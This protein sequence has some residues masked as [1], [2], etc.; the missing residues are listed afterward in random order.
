MANN[1]LDFMKDILASPLGELI[2]SVGQGVADAQAALDAGSLSKLLELYSNED[3]ELLKLMRAVGYQP[4]F[5]VI[6]ETEVEA[7]ISLA[8]SGNEISSAVMGENGVTKQVVSQK[9]IYAAPLNA[10][11][12]NKFNVQAT[13]ATKIKFKIIPVPPTNA[14]A[15]LRVAPNLIGL[16]ETQIEALLV[17]F[18][19]SYSVGDDSGSGAV[20]TQTPEAGSIVKEGDVIVV[21]L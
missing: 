4:T 6:P 20:I 16:T 11:T 10:S 19:L 13:A 14:A 21:D 7:S 5:Y 9:Q 2:S 15:T 17:Q 12:N 1:S 8:I 3:D 18:G